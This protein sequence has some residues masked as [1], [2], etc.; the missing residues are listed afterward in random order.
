MQFSVVLE[1]TNDPANTAEAELIKQQLA[2]AGHRRHARSRTTRPRSSPPR[3]AATSASCCG[4]TT[5]ATTPTRSTSGGTRGSLAELR[6]VQRPDAAGL[7][8]PGPHRDRPG[9]AQG[10]LPA[11]ST[12]ASRQQ[13]YNVWAYYADWVVGAKKNV[14][15]LEGPPLPDGGG[16]PAVLLY[17]R[18]PLLG[19]VRDEVD[20]TSG[21]GRSRDGSLQLVVG[22]HPRRRCSRSPAAAVPG[23]RRRR[24]APVRHQGAEGAV[25]RATTGSTSRSSS[26]TRPGSATS[27]R[28]TSART[29]SRTSPVADKLADRAAGVAA[30][31]ALRADHRAGGR[32]PA[33]RVHRVPRRHQD[34][35][36]DQHRRVRAARAARASC[37]RSRSRTSSGVKWQPDL[38]FL[39]QIPVERLRAG[40]ARRR[41]SAQPT[42]DLGKH[43][44]T[45]LLPAIA[46]AAGLIA[47]YMRLLR[48]DMIATLQENFITM[49]KA[50]G[51]SEPAHPLAPRAPAVEPHAAHRRR[52][53][54]RHAHRR[55]G[56]DRGDLRRSRAWARSSTRPSTPASIVE[57]QSY[58]AII[59]IG[60]VLVNFVVD[61]LYVVLDPRIRRARRLSS[62]TRPMRELVDDAAIGGTPDRRRHHRDRRGRDRPGDAA[63][64]AQGPRASAAWLSIGWMALVVGGAI[65]AP[66]LPIDDPKAIITEIARRGPFADAGTAPGHLLGGDGNGRDMLS[67]LHLGRPHDAASSRPSRCSSASCSAAP[68]G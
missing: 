9:Q 44:G 41:C 40:L 42:G 67:R 53:Q 51:L 1:H 64:Q 59:A 17:G 57:L 4:A 58:I 63:P 61:I 46:L 48:S 10:D 20:L 6:Q 31:H 19:S 7:H 22:R 25:P 24:G 21:W 37:S 27:C 56:R 34:R 47:V 45:M 26:S 52:P 38:P 65:L 29:T 16:K 66:V 55:R 18:H 2:K 33:R 15:G 43:F 32:D 14:Q 12:S 54:R 62:P 23:R 36:R 13:V 3:S 39:G 35:P 8:R 49:A 28:A 30:A 5:P 50:K 60:Y 68:S 11:T